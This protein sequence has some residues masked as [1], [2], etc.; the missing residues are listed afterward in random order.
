MK[1]GIL[2]AVVAVLVG[3]L[4]GGGTFAVLDHN[5]EQQKALK[6]AKD[7]A[8]EASKKLKEASKKT[9]AKAELANAE[10]ESK[11]PVTEQSSSATAES[12]SSATTN[13][14]QLAQQ[15]LV[16]KGYTLKIESYDGMNPDDA[17]SAGA[18]QNLV[19]DGVEYYY[20][21]DAQTVEFTGLGNYN[22]KASDAY[23]VSPDGVQLP[24]GQMIRYQVS[25]GQVTFSN[26]TRTI[27]GH[28]YVYSFSEDA[29]A[30]T[31]VT[32]K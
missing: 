24:G 7:K 15:A 5:R 21:T 22:P 25:D 8:S 13:N 12:A 26:L 11:E 18:P 23:T 10:S 9:S 6:A 28:T 17:M 29:N 30:I 16:G 3:V 2:I 14:V 20:F 31:Y 4:I 19:H 32:S 27:D 1:K